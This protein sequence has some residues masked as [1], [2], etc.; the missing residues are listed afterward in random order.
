MSWSDEKEA[1]LAALLA[2]SKGTETLDEYINRITPRYPPPPHVNPVIQAFERSRHEPVRLTISMPPRSAKTETCM[3]GMAWRMVQDPG[4][5]NAF[6]GATATFAKEKS[7]IIQRRFIEGGG[8]LD[9]K[10]QSQVHWNTIHNGGL[11]SA[12]T[13]THIQGKPINGIALIDDPV[14][15][16]EAAESKLQRDKLWDW[17]NSD[18]MS[19]IEP[20]A[21][22]IVVCTRWHNDDLIG[23]LHSKDYEHEH[24][25][26]INLPAVQ[27]DLGR[28]IDERVLDHDGNVI[29]GQFRAEARS[30][31]P[32][33]RPLTYWESKRLGGEYNWWSLYQGMPTPKGAT[34]FR[35]DPSRFG[36]K[37]FLQNE[38]SKGGY[39]LVIAVDPAASASTKADYSVGA[40]GAAKGYG[41]DMNVYW[42]DVLRGQWTIPALCRHLQTLQAKWRAPMA[43]E[44]VG[45]FRAI[46]DLL[47]EA[48]PNL[49]FLPVELKGD[50]FARSQPY[51][52]AWN[53]HRVHTPYDAI[54]ADDWIAEHASFTGVNDRNDDQ[55][56]AGAHGFTALLRSQPLRTGIDLNYLPL[57]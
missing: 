2:D 36:L 49:L 32:A 5:Y 31:W 12:G 16:R 22:V 39:R 54:W 9:P 18:L 53:D 40:V 14:E 10:S 44:S 4:C 52:A 29:R 25:E 30:L 6:V 56:D 26:E 8:Q 24:Y 34:V 48:N 47:R 46:P 28:P 37:E 13:G 20:G 45:A 27:D 17:F 42:L 43:I 50:K 35:H 21:S 15:G 41:D 11:F 38:F 7:R 3:N 55:V 19:R 33:I 1:E 57:G 51:A 23:R